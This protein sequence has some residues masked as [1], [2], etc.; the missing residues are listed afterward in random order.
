MATWI[1]LEKSICLS[2][3]TRESPFSS[4]ACWCPSVP[5]DEQIVRGIWCDRRHSENCCA[6]PIL[7]DNPLLHQWLAMCPG[8]SPFHGC[9]C[10]LLLAQ[11]GVIYD[12]NLNIALSISQEL[13]KSYCHWEKWVILPP[14][15]V[16]LQRVCPKNFTWGSSPRSW[17]YRAGKIVSNLISVSCVAV[18]VLTFKRAVAN[19]ST[20]SAQAGA[21]SGADLERLQCHSQ[22][23][24]GSACV[25][26]LYLHIKFLTR[27]T[28][29]SEFP[30]CC[31]NR[32]ILSSVDAH[33]QS[34]LL[35]V[36]SPSHRPSCFAHCSTAVPASVPLTHPP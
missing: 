8:H 15:G 14:L 17:S 22:M 4:P 23:F 19:V 24:E 32:G 9:I 35:P 34:H 29:P 21:T 3:N 5:S 11:T 7:S 6:C 30:L 25:R 27:K 18:L 10:F 28:A 1:T 2:I 12:F 16:F 36:F 13:S 20:K 26:V 31:T 33:L